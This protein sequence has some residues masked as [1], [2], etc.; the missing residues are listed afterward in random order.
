MPELPDGEVWPSRRDIG[1]RPDGF[2][3]ALPEWWP[4]RTWV[5]ALNFLL[6][7]WTG[8]RLAREIVSVSPG[9]RCDDEGNVLAVTDI[10]I[11]R[12][13]SL[14]GPVLPLSGWWGPYVRLRRWW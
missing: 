13:W 5:G 2:W 11:V 8:W 12:R 10:A 4:I 3:R 1:P 14:V 7:Q 9:Y 6:L